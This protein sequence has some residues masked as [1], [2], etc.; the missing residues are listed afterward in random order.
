MRAKMR[1]KLRSRTGETIAETLIALLISALA[2][3]ML[4]GAISTAA[5]LVIKSNRQMSK[6]YSADKKLVEQNAETDDEGYTYISDN[7]VTIQQSG[8]ESGTGSQQFEGV[9]VYQNNAFS[10]I[11]VM[12]YSIQ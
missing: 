11:P 1:T 9:K 6:Y 5:S 2:L 8:S 4:A 12:A 10:G 3:T 7:T